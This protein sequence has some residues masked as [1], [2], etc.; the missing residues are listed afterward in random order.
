MSSVTL[1]TNDI[2]LYNVFLNSKLFDEVNIAA[3]ID[4]KTEYDNLIVSDRL[5]GINDLIEQVETGMKVRKAAYL[6]SSN[7]SSQSGYTALTAL[8][9]THNISILPP[10]LT[11][12]QIL[13]RFCDLI[14]LQ[15]KKSNNVIVFFGADSKVGT[16]I[17]AL[18]ISEALAAQ[19]EGNV[20]FL[21]LSGHLSKAY[22]E[23]NDKGLD[24]IR[25]KV[26]NK[27]LSQDE[28][29]GAM[30]QSQDQKNLYILPPCRT[31]IDFKYYQTDHVEYLI[32]MASNMFEVVIV[33]AGW[34][35]HNN[36]YFGAINYTQNRYMV[37]TQDS[38][39]LTCHIY[40]KEQA[41]DEYGITS[42][43]SDRSSTSP[44]NIMLILNKYDDQ[45]GTNIT[46]EYDMVYALSLPLVLEYSYQHKLDNRTLSGISKGYDYQLDKLTNLIALQLDYKIASKKK[47]P[48]SIWEVFK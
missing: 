38:D 37:A 7:K 39:I 2:D 29:R 18:G 33:D 32:Q 12:G 3:S 5:C 17:T 20:A 28:L 26:F 48:F 16:T 14:N 15:E 34:Y 43:K 22:V 25:Y 21:N 36:L 13:S 44:E 19:G 45:Y 8:L 4:V 1:I 10:K 31:L 30:V 6:L 24:S 41:L 11:E 46:K 42:R 35:P 40:I 47:K 23:A 9:K 27:I